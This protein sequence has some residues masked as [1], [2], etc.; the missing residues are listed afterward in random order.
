MRSARPS[1]GWYFRWAVFISRHEYL[2]AFLVFAAIS[3]S[4]AGAGLLLRVKELKIA[5]IFVA[6]SGLL[7]FAVSVAGLYRFYGKPSLRYYRRIIDAVGLLDRGPISIAEMHIGT[8]RH[9]YAL[10]DLLPDVTI[11][12]IDCWDEEQSPAYGSLAALRAAETPPV[13]EPRIQ[14]LKAK[15]WKVPIA[16]ASCDAVVLGIGIHEFEPA[17]REQLFVE[18]ARILK[19]RGK[20]VLFEHVRNVRN[21]LVFGLV[22][23]HWPKR[24]EW[25]C[26]LRRHFHDVKHLPVWP[27]IDL[28]TG[29]RP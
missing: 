27:A 22:V 24:N 20:V 15:L 2:K 1:P 9:A 17:A 13:N 10:A 26:T 3:A 11:Q 21:S 29:I 19:P 4:L 6:G 7:L 23:G 12:S 14:A 28:F 5:G 8:Y 25:I 16:D 18:A